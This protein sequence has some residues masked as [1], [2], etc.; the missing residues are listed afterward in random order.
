[1]MSDLSIFEIRVM[2]A[3]ADAIRSSGE[4]RPEP[5]VKIYLSKEK[6]S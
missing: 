3:L 4:E 2:E 1:M 5:V 6:E